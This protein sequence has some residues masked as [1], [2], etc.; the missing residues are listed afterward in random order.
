MGNGRDNASTR[1]ESP[2]VGRRGIQFGVSRPTQTIAVFPRRPDLKVSEVDIS[3][4]LATLDAI[5]FCVV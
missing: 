3:V 4:W 1:E 5:A 2:S